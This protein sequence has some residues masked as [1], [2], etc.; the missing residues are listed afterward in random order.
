MAPLPDGATGEGLAFADCGQE[1]ALG[2]LRYIFIDFN[3]YFASVEQHDAPELIG[4]PV[5]VIPLNSEHSGAIAASYEAKALGIKRGTTVREARA[6][7]A[8]V[9]V[10][11]ARHDRYVMMHHELLKEIER[12]VPIQR[13]C[14]IDECVCRLNPEEAEPEAAKALARR[15][16][17]GLAARFGPAMRCSIGLASSTLLAKLASD[18]KKPDGLSVIMPESLPGRLRDLP[19]E[20]IPGVGRGVSQR[21]IR[22]GI[23][24]FTSLWNLAP[25]QARAI[26]GSVTGERFIYGLKGHD[27]PDGAAPKKAMI[28]HSRVLSGAHRRPEGARIVARALLLKAASRLRHYGMYASGLHLSLRFYPEGR[29]S[30]EVRFRGSQNSW[31]FLEKL[32]EMWWPMMDWLADP[33]NYRDG[34]RRSIKLAAVH[35]FALKN[36]PP[37][38]DLFVSVDSDHRDALQAGLWQRIDDANRKYGMETLILASQKGMDL[39]Y[40]GVKIAF[41]R[42]PDRAEFSDRSLEDQRRLTGMAHHDRL[43]QNASRSLY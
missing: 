1:N 40:L 9:A 17:A 13:V 7:C 16:K 36:S 14:S 23:T 34:R 27:V 12:H 30:Q 29:L 25:K 15:I 38:R 8:D 35:L 24:D 33:R 6:I 3:A 19:L 26:W 11:P 2:G 18:L 42:V 10:L 41:S 28:G 22:A 5:I 37:E 39:N 4:R 21:L 31:R 32:D 43:R 20:A